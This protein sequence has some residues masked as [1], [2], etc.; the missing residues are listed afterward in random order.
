MIQALFAALLLLAPLRAP[1]SEL[2]EVTVHLQAGRISAA[3]KVLEPLARRY[4]AD[5]YVLGFL[6]RSRLHAGD[7][8][9][10]IAPLKKS[11]A[12][13]TTDAEGFN[14]LGS[15]LIQIERLQPAVEA[16]ARAVALMPRNHNALRNLAAA[17]TRVDAHPAAAATWKRYVELVPADRAARCLYGSVLLALDRP[18]LAAIELRSGSQGNDDVVCLHDFADAL[19]RIGEP[20]QALAMLDR[21]VAIDP[22]NAHAH[23]LRAYILVDAPGDDRGNPLTRAMAAIDASVKAK[24]KR[25][26]AHHLRGYILARLR[27]ANEALTAYQ[28]A[29]DLEPK[30]AAYSEA[31]AVAR[32]RAGEG[33]RVLRQLRRLNR[34]DPKNIEV[35]RAL[36]QVLGEKKE[37]RRALKVLQATASKAPML[38]KDRAAWLLASGRVD[39]ARKVLLEGL[40]AAP[41]HRDLQFNLALTERRSGRFDA[42]RNY[43]SSAL[44]SC[45]KEG[46]LCSQETALMARLELQLGAPKAARE[47]T[48]K[49]TPTTYDSSFLCAR[50]LRV[51]GQLPKALR[52]AERARELA[53]DAADRSAAQ[54]LRG[55]I[56]TDLGRGAEAIGIFREK[57]TSLADLGIALSRAGRAR[58]AKAVLLRALRKDS[59]NAELHL[60]LASA[61]RQ[62]GQR[63]AALGVL[64]AARKR[65][66]EKP[67]VI[68]DLALI[69]LTEKTKQK[70]VRLLLDGVAKHPGHIQLAR[71]AA[72]HLSETGRHKEAQKVMRRALVL[73]PNY[74]VLRTAFGDVLWAAG[75]PDKADRSY[76]D[77]G[78]CATPDQRALSR[79]GDLARRQRKLGKAIDLYRQAIEAD[80]TLVEAYNGMAMSHHGLEQ[81]ERAVA[82]YRKGLAVDRNDPVLNNNLG[83]TLYL[84][85]K[86][87]AAL[88]VFQRAA[89]VDPKEGRY[90][91]NQIMVLKQMGRLEAAEKVLE[92][93]KK[94][95]PAD[96]GW[97]NEAISLRKAIELRERVMKDAVPGTGK[98]QQLR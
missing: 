97:V 6:G 26:A 93:G 79:R 71:N 5:P 41:T 52:V 82:T 34:R 25:A 87:R 11:L 69:Y 1:Q 76:R 75:L 15:A 23:Y 64:E 55:K 38:V 28:R 74:G 7:P 21:L 20:T 88:T 30:N 44:K 65:W 56:L 68:N 61:H 84:Q 57:G 35:A 36:A 67:G 46:V 10:S 83:S 4:P 27:R 17:Q 50:S 47:L 59:K 2:R 96:P 91:R 66:P 14:N 24:P 39:A 78:R 19:G 53:Q 58:E 62:L 9:G 16:F 77:A 63:T 89:T 73:R 80:A 12:Q 33:R 60:A 48:C 29:F 40:K 31:V 98:G 32:V 51:L 43:A 37:Y 49:A 95:L 3:L 8:A 54:R 85:G 18:R 42:A 86:F 70:G 94:A 81:F 45:K 13:L 72:Q 90:W 92:Q 22:G